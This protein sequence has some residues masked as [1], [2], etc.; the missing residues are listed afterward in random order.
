MLND[1]E[2]KFK[3][4]TYKMS[5]HG[6]ARDYDFKVIR[7]VERNILFEKVSTGES[8]KKYPFDFVLHVKYSLFE[9]S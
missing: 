8:R 2:Y 7:K 6:F 3:G 4:K 9:K 1:E 5:N